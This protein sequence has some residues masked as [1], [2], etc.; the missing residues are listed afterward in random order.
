MK[1]YITHMH[2][3]A[4]KIP[5]MLLPSKLH[6][7]N[8][9][10]KVLRIFIFLECIVVYDDAS[11]TA[12]DKNIA[13]FFSYDFIYDFAFIVNVINWITSFLD[14]LRQF[15]NLFFYKHLLFVCV[16]FT[17]YHI[18]TIY[19]LVWTAAIYDRTIEQI[20]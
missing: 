14:F 4:A 15:L 13:K 1:L 7:K 18:V 10:I 20:M 17:V 12:W 19:T 16:N 11:R 8:A 3:P 9:P 2:K 6:C 5:P